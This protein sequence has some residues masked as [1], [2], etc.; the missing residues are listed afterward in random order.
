MRSKPNMIFR[1]RLPREQRDQLR[2][3]AALLAEQV[4]AGRSFDCL[5]TGDRQ[6]RDLNRDFLGHDY[7]TDVLSFPSGV[8]DP[9]GELA[10]SWDR[11][12]EQAAAHG[13]DAL[14]E[15]QILMLHG[16]L[17]L[18]GM[19]HEKDRGQMRRAERKWRQSFG[20]PSGLIERAAR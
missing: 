2:V 11:A 19:D 14:T 6:L 1:K 10:I 7:A 12:I 3:F 17:H 4:L 8:E 18:A 16:V 15:V 13:H 20:L 9:A 5:L